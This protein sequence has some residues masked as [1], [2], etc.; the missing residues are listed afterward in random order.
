MAKD[1]CVLA[2]SGGLDTS[3]CLKW[4]Q[5]EKGLGIKLY[6]LVDELVVMALVAPRVLL[7]RT[8]LKALKQRGQRFKKAML[9]LSAR[10]NGCSVGAMRAA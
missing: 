3:V 7:N 2:Y 4:L 8:M 10:F 6:Y 9:L 1:K 5:D